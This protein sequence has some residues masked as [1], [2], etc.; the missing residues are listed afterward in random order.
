MSDTLH[1]KTYPIQEAL[2]A[3]QALRNLAGLEPEMFPVEA[4]V[5]MISDEVEALRKRGHS[6]AQIA[7]TIQDNSSIQ[8]T[9]AEVAA[10]YA[11]PEDRHAHHG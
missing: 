5:G 2:R 1:E 11:S 6:D 8:I 9:A 10:Y 3:Q 4:F 7:K